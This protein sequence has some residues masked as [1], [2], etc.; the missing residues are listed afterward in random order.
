MKFPIQL[1]GAFVKT[2]LRGAAIGLLLLCSSATSFGAASVV[3]FDGFNGPTLN[4]LWAGPLPDAPGASGDTTPEAY[5]GFPNY[6]L[7]T[8]GAD[9]LL[10][11]SN[12]LSDLQRVGWSLNTNFYVSDFRYE[13]RF[14]TLVQSPGTSIDACVEI[15]ILDATDASRYDIVSLFGGSYGSDRRFRAGSSISGISTDQPFAYEDN[16]FYRLVLEGNSTNNL[17]ASLWDDQ[18]N[19]LASFD[20][21]H[22]TAAFTG[23]F[24]IAISQGMDRPLGTYPSD[25]AVDYTLL[26]TTN[27]P[28]LI[29]ASD[30]AGVQVS[31]PS[32]TNRWYQ[33]QIPS[34]K[35]G[36]DHQSGWIDF[37][38]PIQGTGSDVSA[39]IP[40]NKA[41]IKYRVELLP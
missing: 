37:G 3:F 16:H 35:K 25:V 40:G 12:S 41:Q 5:V 17:H 29:K 21:G 13:T 8:V 23:G 11:M 24:R 33:L 18:G 6:Q 27:T 22:N 9:S 19:E 39:F 31:W 7:Q 28:S 26:T 15:W 30:T 4:P 32:V 2:N 1:F 36:K 20:I 14:N 38:D 34:M 10:R